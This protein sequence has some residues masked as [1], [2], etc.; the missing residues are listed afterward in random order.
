MYDGIPSTS[1]PAACAGVVNAP[2]VG[3][4]PGGDPLA[5]CLS[6]L[7]FRQFVTYQPGSR[8]WAFQGIEAGL[9][10]ALAA[11]LLAVTFY[12]IRHRDA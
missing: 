3:G 12:V 2:G 7:G 4:P 5:A 8:Y 9:Y 1:I 11:A 10:V 6:R